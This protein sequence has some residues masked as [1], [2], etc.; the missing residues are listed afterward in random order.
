L[1]AT[2]LLHVIAD[3]SAIQASGFKAIARSLFAAGLEKIALHLRAHGMA[4]RVLYEAVADI[5]PAARETASWLVVNDRI[6]VALA[7]GLDHVLLGVRSLPV[8]TA[9][10]LLGNAATIGY[11]AHA[12]EEAEQ[13]VAHGANFIVLGTIYET[14]SH[15]GR[16]AAG[17]Q[18]VRDTAAAVRRPIIA[19]GGITTTRVA[20]VT[21]AG[22]AGVA[23]LSG[24]WSAPDAAGAAK[25]YLD[26]L[27]HKGVRT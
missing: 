16:A 17:V 27:Q 4:G 7:A 23:V 9:R 25:E 26:V 5:A 2:P 21:A 24:I 13:A 10:A 3:E 8:A 20:E 18:L 6:D 12:P 11:S 1:S 19:I 22:A 15:P 14:Q